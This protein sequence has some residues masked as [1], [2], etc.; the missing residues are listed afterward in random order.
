MKVE[1]KLTA[2]WRQSASA[3]SMIF[4]TVVNKGILGPRQ[5]YSGSSWSTFSG[6][7][8]SK[9]SYPLQTH[10]QSKMQRAFLFTEPDS[11]RNQ[12]RLLVVTQLPRLENKGP[13]PMQPLRLKG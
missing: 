7:D 11:D 9:M 13:R 5:A 2:I 6:F 3:R 10:F 8:A 1:N 4:P 12:A